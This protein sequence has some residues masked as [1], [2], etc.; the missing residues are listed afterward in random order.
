MAATVNGRHAAGT[1]R[2]RQHETSN[3]RHHQDQL[4]WSL[5]FFL[6]TPIDR[7]KLTEKIRFIG[8][9][10]STKPILTRMTTAKTANQLNKK[11][12]M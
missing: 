12:K 6:H 2:S 9:T 5:P 10:Y 3:N 1:R 4:I 11:N 8:Q 7:T